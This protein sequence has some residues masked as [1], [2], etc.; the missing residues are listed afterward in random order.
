M[1]I[2]DRV[3]VIPGTMD[4]LRERGWVADYMTESVDGKSGIITK[5]CRDAPD[6]AHWSVDLG[7]LFPVGIPERY[8]TLGSDRMARSKSTR[9]LLHI[10]GAMDGKWRRVKGSFASYPASNTN[11]F[12]P[13]HYRRETLAAQD[14][15]FDVMI[16]SGATTGNALSMLIQG[17]RPLVK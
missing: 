13:H 11:G 7:L 4:A 8:L 1:K 14:A 9:E 17:Y 16:Y 15:V 6:G 3:T 5:D 2:G 12:E 10:G